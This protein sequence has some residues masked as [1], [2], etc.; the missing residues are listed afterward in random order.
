MIRSPESFRLEIEYLKNGVVEKEDFNSFGSRRSNH[1]VMMRGTF[2][3]GLNW[4]L[5]NNNILPG[6]DGEVLKLDD[7]LYALYYAPQGYD[8]RAGADIR[9]AV[10]KGSLNDMPRHTEPLVTTEEIKEAMI[11]RTAAN[12]YYLSLFRR[13]CGFQQDSVSI[14]PKEN[15]QRACEPL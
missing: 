3:D 5:V 13:I 10:Y 4:K 7:E 6:L 9:L 8:D 14:F 2:N 1:E 11:Q 12:K 15:P